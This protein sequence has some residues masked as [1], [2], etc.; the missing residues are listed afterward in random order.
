MVHTCPSVSENTKVTAKWVAKFCEEA[1][2]NDPCTTITTI[3]NTSTSKY[4]VEISTHMA[5]R[6]KKAAKNV[7]LGDQKAQYTR[8]R[9]YLQAVL[10]T[11]PGSRCIVTTRYLREH[12]SK[13]PRFH[14]LSFA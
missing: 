14:A 10:D 6:A 7:V 13:N 1:I 8:I 12:P 2:R 3:I 9:D 5:Y 4:G 11:N